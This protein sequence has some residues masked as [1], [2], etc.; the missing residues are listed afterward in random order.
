MATK[1]FD[2]STLVLREATEEERIAC[3]KANGTSW[4][5]KLSLEDYL[6]FSQLNSRSALARDGGARYW[7]FTGPGNAEDGEKEQI[8]ASLETLRKPIVIKTADGKV[9][10]EW[11]HGV[12]GVWTMVPFRGKKIGTWLMRKTRDWLDSEDAKARV[13]ALFSGIGV[14]MLM[15][16]R[17]EILGHGPILTV[18]TGLVLPTWLACVSKQAACP[19]ACAVKP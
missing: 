14:C 12:A 10:T 8:Y 11:G 5:K 17:I 9:S 13:S 2:P 6:T 7:V 16:F 18:P 1:D 4:A 15:S 19:T 3:W